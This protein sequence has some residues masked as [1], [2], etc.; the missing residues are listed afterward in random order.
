MIVRARTSMFKEGDRV[1]YILANRI[2][3][4]VCLVFVVPTKLTCIELM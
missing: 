1:T 2:S 4:L 3:I